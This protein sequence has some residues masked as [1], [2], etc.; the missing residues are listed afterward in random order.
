MSTIPLEIFAGAGRATLIATDERSA[1]ITSLVWNRC[2]TPSCLAYHHV[3]NAI[4][5]LDD[6]QIWESD[7]AFRQGRSDIEV[8]KV[9]K[10]AITAG[11]GHRVMF[12]AAGLADK[13]T[14]RTLALVAPSGTGKT[15]AVHKLG[16]Y[17]GYVT[18]ETVI[19]NP[20]TLAITPYP[21]PL[22]LLGPE[23]RYPKTLVSPDELG[24]G[25]TPQQPQLH[26]VVVLLRDEH[27][28]I[29]PHVK[30][31]S[32]VEALQHVVPQTS[33]LSALERGLEHVASLFL[34]TGG[35][36][37]VRYHEAEDLKPIFDSLLSE[38]LPPHPAA[39]WQKMPIV[40]SQATSSGA[41]ASQSEG[42]MV[43]RAVY[44]DALLIDGEKLAI[45]H[46]EEFTVLHGLGTVIWQCL[47]KPYSRAELVRELSNAQGA[48]PNARQQVNSALKNLY[49]RGLIFDVNNG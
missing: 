26:R 6:Q 29:E 16:R 41:I 40:F 9:T 24:M 47:T 7:D 23:K 39:S 28:A 18:D 17:Y 5:P 13:S 45:L 14:Q 22:S 1:G 19:I 49:D 4:E 38:D 31:L 46:G 36:L 12:H 2:L 27:I 21:K 32:L 11:I 8:Q 35:C 33:S 15:T 3:K 37:A 42:S 44:D 30:Q 34:R 25:A 48:P 20:R 43:A 10:A